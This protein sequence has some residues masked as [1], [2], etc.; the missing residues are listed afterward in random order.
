M[1]R[2][3]RAESVSDVDEDLV[4]L[5]DARD[6]EVGVAPK[7]AAHRDGRLHRAVSV[8]LFD[9]A[10]RV[11]LQRRAGG[12]YHSG[13]LW[14][15][16]CCGHP[17]PGESVTDAARR[18]LSNELGIEGA[19]LVRVS[20]FVYFAQLDGGLIEHELDH[21]VIGRW[22]GPIAPDA[23]EVSET[24]W[25]EPD[26]LFAELATACDRYTAWTD[27]VVRHACLYGDALRIPGESR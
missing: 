14:S 5:V 1:V 16:T 7:L 12:K 3:T 2:E 27:R 9:D 20:D 10:G 8:V 22:T 25:I 4:V 15:N 18:R 21:V 6:A 19:N 11:L 13:G 24:R 17:R 26:V 23:G